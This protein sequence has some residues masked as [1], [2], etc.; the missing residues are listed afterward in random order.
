MNLIRLCYL[1]TILCLTVVTSGCASGPSEIGG[2]PQVTAI[3]ASELPRPI[4]VDPITGF[5]P[6]ILGPSDVLTITVDGIE[7]LSNLETRID[8]GG[9]IAVP[10]AGSV[11]VSG[12][13][14][15][16]VGVLLREELIT[17][18]KMVNPTVTVNIKEAPSRFVTV[19]GEVRRPGNYEIS[20]NMT[21]MRTIALAQGT[22]ELSKLDDVVIFRKVGGQQF[23]ALYD[24]KAIRHGAYA[25]PEVYPND[26]VM[27][28]DER[29]RRLFREILQILPALASPLIIALDRFSN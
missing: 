8:A 16:E 22:Q 17:R 19:E 15:Q 23:A 29:A 13:T 10:L 2:S 18:G 7:W 27:V 4:E 28:G 25:D 1:G 14:P 20:N 6:Q 21:L 11:M 9:R 3:D 12:L 5:I 26:I 24:L